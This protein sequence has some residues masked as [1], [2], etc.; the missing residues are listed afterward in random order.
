MD[1]LQVTVAEDV[2]ALLVWLSGNWWEGIVELL[3]TVKFDRRVEMLSCWQ[4]SF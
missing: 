4:C 3:G 2:L 1:L